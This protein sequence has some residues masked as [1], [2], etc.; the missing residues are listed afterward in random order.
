VR[1]PD[2]V[3]SHAAGDNVANRPAREGAP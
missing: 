2:V 3:E 1:P